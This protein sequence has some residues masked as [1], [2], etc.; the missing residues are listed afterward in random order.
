MTTTASVTSSGGSPPVV[1]NESLLGAGDSGY[2]GCQSRSESGAV[3]QPWSSQEP[4]AHTRTAEN[5]PAAGLDSAYCRNPDGEPT[6]WCYTMDPRLRWEFCAPL[7]AGPTTVAPTT[8]APTSDAPTSD[9]PTTYAPTTDAPG[10]GCNEELMGD[11]GSGYRGCQTATRTGK[12]CQA[13]A[14]QAPHEHSRTPETYP[15]AGLAGNFCRNPD[16]EPT[17]WCYTTDPASRW[18]FCDPLDA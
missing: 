1:C 11:G 4:H 18:E 14:E 13:W 3:C 5:Y 17:I 10:G 12:A 16:N 9:A 2:R 15:D 8:D 6:I 7:P